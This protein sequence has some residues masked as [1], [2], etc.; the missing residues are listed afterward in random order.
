M[1]VLTTL[2]PNEPA[3]VA[4]SANLPPEVR[5]HKLFAPPVYPGA[6]RRRVI[7]D[8][9]LQNNSLRVTV[10][11]GPAGHGKSTTLQQIK[12]AHEARGWRT[13]WLTLDDADNDPRRFESHLRALMQS[14]QGRT[15]SPPAARAALG[16][17]PL[18]LAAWVLDGLTAIDTHASIF[19]DEF[20]TLRND[21]LLRFFRTLLPRL[22]AH[23]HVFIGSRALPEVGLA[24]LLVNRLAC[25][26]RADELRFTPG[27]ATEFFA[28]SKELQ[29]SAE[30]L[31]TI[32]RRT[33]G[34]PAG[35]Q[36]FR[37]ALASPEVRTSLE[38]L[39]DTGPRELAEY[40]TDNV[41]TLQSPR[42]QEFLFRTSLLRRLSAPLCAA[43]TGFDDAQAL[44]A[45]L[46]RSG[47]FL[48]ALDSDNTWFKYH[49][50]FSSFLADSLRRSA[51]QDAARVHA[52]AARWYLAADL[53][54]EAMHHALACE[55]YPLAADTLTDWSSH[56]IASAELITLERWYDRLPFEHVACRPALAIHAAYSLMFLRRRAKLRPLVR[57]LGQQAG[58]GDIGSTTNPDLCRAMA[59]VLID[60][61]F[62]AA[63]R[64]IDR[65]DLLDHEAEGFP[66]FE[67][68]AAANVL[69]FG[70]IARGDFE[71][72]RKSLMLASAHFERGA[73]SFVR[74]YTVAITGA[75]LLVQGRLQDAIERFRAES[76]Q[77]EPLDTSVAAAAR[78]ACQ[79]W[80]VY[81]SNDLATLEPLV[82]RFQRDIADSV[83]LDFIAVALLSI[84]R[85]H[86]ARGR[87]TEA[88]EA[89]D[90]LERIG[91]ES[92][93]KRLIS[94]ADWERVR[95]ALLAGELDRAV[96]LAARIPADPPP[97]DPHWIDLAEDMEG[98]AYGRIRLAIAQGDLAQAGRRIG[99]ER[100]RQTGRVYRDI[101]LGVL[102]ALLQHHRGSPSG[103]HRSLRKA[104]QLAREGRFVRCI[105]DEGDLV[106][107]L[108]REQ[109]QQLLQT[110]EGVPSDAE[111][112]YLELL[113]AASGTDLGRPRT[114]CQLVDPLSEREKEMLQL[115]ADGVSNKEIAA[116]LFVSENTVKFHLKNVYSKLGVGSRLQAINAARALRLVS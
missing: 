73:G 28:E 93:W 2:P 82:T 11:Q 58:S 37:L 111:R 67:F 91:H 21:A 34:W 7:L 41:V 79:I 46:E 61:D 85:L 97:A 33:E 104:L 38:N 4:S 40:L 71:G 60:D 29:V 26:L 101:K 12:T 106:L 86:Q 103:A 80:A 105:L 22:P 107:Q 15:A 20:Q 74:G 5:S 8:R 76:A 83:T 31:G 25:V 92:Q 69:S 81:E 49:G 88:L 55:D 98:E 116:R 42:I 32:Y 115:L 47:L 24:T 96:A 72:A 6:V 100:L 90:E 53:P 13:A 57:L 50:L 108:L 3:A 89:L 109:Y 48:R 35:L 1:Q 64:I 87:S 62:G 18:D 27:E 84:S 59:F 10:L 44:L 52:E 43:V 95:C 66:S 23:V 56:L 102:E 36:L 70:R 19:L 75:R 17:A 112:E 65:P 30:E 54:E 51:P 63:L 77:Q 14:L 16:D 9:V 68:G 99:Q 45:Q 110:G 78:A 113:L 39:D 94:L 114:R